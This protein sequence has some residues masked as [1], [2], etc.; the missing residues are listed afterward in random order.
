MKTIKTLLKRIKTE[1]AKLEKQIAAAYANGIKDLLVESKNLVGKTISLN[2]PVTTWYRGQLHYRVT[3]IHR[4]TRDF[5]TDSSG[6]L[7]LEFSAELV[8]KPKNFRRNYER[9]V[10][11]VYRKQLRVSTLA[12]V[13]VLSK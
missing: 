6:P 5:Y 4:L 13:K 3:K 7:V 11:K 12:D 10:G 1:E 9:R 8:R 2:E